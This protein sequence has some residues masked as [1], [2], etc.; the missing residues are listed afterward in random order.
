MDITGITHLRIQA[1]R[2]LD[3]ASDSYVITSQGGDGRRFR[4][5]RRWLAPRG[6][7]IVEALAVEGITGTVRT[8]P[9]TAYT[10]VHV[11]V[12]A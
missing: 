3:G 5:G 7:D 12:G 10:L 1:A 8:Y 11:E 2:T 9:Y 6:T 4:T